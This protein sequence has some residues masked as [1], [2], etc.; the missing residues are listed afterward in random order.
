MAGVPAQYERFALAAGASATA[1]SEARRGFVST[2]PSESLL[3]MSQLDA[4]FCRQSGVLF[5]VLER[6]A[7]HW[8]VDAAQGLVFEVSVPESS[9]AAYNAAVEE[10]GKI[11]REQQALQ[12]KLVKQ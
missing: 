7:G 10:I 4:D 3:L 2:F 5:D 12:E 6:H 9:I 11:G 1:A 8:Q